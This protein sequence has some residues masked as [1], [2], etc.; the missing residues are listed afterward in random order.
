MHNVADDVRNCVR[1]RGK[2]MKRR[3]KAEGHKVVQKGKSK[4]FMVE[5]FEKSLVKQAN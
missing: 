4:H 5:D 1:K 2:N 3:L